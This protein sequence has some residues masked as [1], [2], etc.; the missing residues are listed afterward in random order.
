MGVNAYLQRVELRAKEAQLAQF[1]EM[2]AQ[3]V[4]AWPGGTASATEKVADMRAANDLMASDTV[5]AL[6]EHAPDPPRVKQ[7]IDEL[8][9]VLDRADAASQKEPTLRKEI[10]MVYRRIGDVESAAPLP[11][12][13]NK[14]Q[15]ADSYRRAAVI[16]ADL[17]RVDGSWANQQINELSGLLNGLGAPLETALAQ[18]TPDVAGHDQP[19]LEPSRDTRNPPVAEPKAPETMTLRE[20]DPEARADVEQR[21]RSMTADAERARRS[22]ETLRDSLAARG[23]TVRGDVEGILTEVDGLIDE[24][25]GLLKQND[26][27]NAEDYLRRASYQLKRVFQT[28][29]G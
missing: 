4:A 18:A 23:Q 24:A 10:A 27:A 28:V 21:L 25:R 2:L 19:A 1:V 7:L 12:I 26:L 6:A 8:R 15:A 5:R 16:A 11:A 20:V 14:Q 17:R 22:F 29:G 13:A 9:G 3:K